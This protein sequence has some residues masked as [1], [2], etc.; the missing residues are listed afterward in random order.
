MTPLRC[1]ATALAATLALSIGTLPAAA[2]GG[3][4][5]KPKVKTNAV[6]TASHSGKSNGSTMHAPKS[7]GSAAASHGPKVKATSNQSGS[8]GKSHTATKTATNSGAT[9]AKGHGK[10]SKGTTNAGTG[11][12][13]GGSSLATNASGNGGGAGTNAGGTNGGGSN[14][15]GSNDNGG[16][17]QNK[18][19]QLLAKNDNLRGKCQSRLPA[20]TDVNAAAAGFR[21]LGQFVAA[22]NVS[23]NLGLDFAALKALMTGDHPLSLGQSIQRLRGTTPVLS[24]QLAT[25]AMAQANA[26][27]RATTNDGRTNGTNA[28]GGTTNTNGGS[29]SGR[30]DTNQG[31]TSNNPGHN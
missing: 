10:A 14:G 28:T 30:T 12:G 19:Q 2:K 15:G 23:H 18:A 5:N 6:H 21:N 31:G 9:Q 20:G 17:P 11:N 8:H 27:I 13:N 3:G 26:Q 7:N 16:L 29:T 1:I 4:S 22:V 24:E 25:N